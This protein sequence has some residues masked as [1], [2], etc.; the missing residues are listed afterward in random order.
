MNNLALKQAIAIA[1]AGHG[2]AGKL[3]AEAIEVGVIVPSILE[4]RLKAAGFT[5]LS[6]LPGDIPDGKAEPLAKLSEVHIRRPSTDADHVSHG[7]SVLVARA[8]SHD[9]PDALV[10]AMWG[11]V[12]EEAAAVLG[13]KVE[14]L[15]ES[16]KV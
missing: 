12:K 6:W 9:R 14:A 13:V 11:A 10:Q 3:V 1:K 5:V 7:D 15:I 2:P 16:L 8:V 4:A